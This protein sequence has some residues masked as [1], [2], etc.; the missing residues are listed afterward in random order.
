MY[1]SRKTR[2]ISSWRSTIRNGRVVYLW[3]LG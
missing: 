3:T 2:A 1:R